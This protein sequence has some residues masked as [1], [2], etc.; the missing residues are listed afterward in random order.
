M[1]FTLMEKNL[2]KKKLFSSN[3]NFLEGDKIFLNHELILELN[4][5]FD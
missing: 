2:I 4:L 5:E 1:K 3:L